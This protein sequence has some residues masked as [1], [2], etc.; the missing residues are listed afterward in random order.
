MHLLSIAI[1]AKD[2]VGVSP[3]SNVFGNFKRTPDEKNTL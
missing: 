1:E 3:M 2:V